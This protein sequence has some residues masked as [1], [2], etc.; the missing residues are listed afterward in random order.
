MTELVFSD[1]AVTAYTNY[2]HHDKASNYKALWVVGDRSDTTYN[3][4]VNLKN[5]RKK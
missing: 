1:N 3:F 2:C 5:K 4:F